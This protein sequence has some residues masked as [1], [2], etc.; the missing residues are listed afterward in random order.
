MNSATHTTVMVKGCLQ[1]V[2]PTNYRTEWCKEFFRGKCSNGSSCT[3][4]H[5]LEQLRVDAAIEAGKLN[6]KFKMLFCGEANAG[7]CTVSVVRQEMCIAP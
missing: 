6:S 2:L 1:G 5:T 3:R 7:G 4:A